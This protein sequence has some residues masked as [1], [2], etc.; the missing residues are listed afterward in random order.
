MRQQRSGGAGRAHA[1]SVAQRDLVAAHR[2]QRLRHTGLSQRTEVVSAR[3]GGREGYLGN[4]QHL[5]GLHMALI[6]TAQH[7][8]H[9]PA[10]PQ[11]LRQRLA[12][13]LWGEGRQAGREGQRW[14]APGRYVYRQRGT[15]EKRFM[16]SSTEQL[17]LFLLKLSEAAPNTARGARVSARIICARGVSVRV[18]VRSLGGLSS[19]LSHLPISLTPAFSAASKPTRLGVR[20]DSATLPLESAPILLLAASSYTCS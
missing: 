18:S 12:A 2:E 15:S 16:L 1:D 7:A 8:R 14:R 4:L 3:E 9:V 13:H 6:G 5:L 20:A 17:M 19:L 11:P 10:H